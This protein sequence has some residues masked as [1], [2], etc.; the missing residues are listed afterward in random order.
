[1]QTSPANPSTPDGSPSPVLR[2]FLR[3][4]ADAAEQT[5][6]RIRI[7][8]LVLVQIRLLAVALPAFLDGT[9]KHW[10][11]TAVIAGG[12]GA[13]IALVRAI[14]AAPDKDRLLVLSTVLDAVLAFLIVLPSVVWPRQGYLGVIAAPDF[15][16][17]PLVATGAGLRL[18]RRAA[19]AGSSAAIAGVLGLVLIDQLANADRIA[20]GPAEVALAAVLM[21]GATLLALGLERRIRSLVTRGAD[22]ALRAE[23]AR[24]RLGAYVSEEVAAK[25]MREPDAMFGTERLDAAVLFSDLRGFTRTGE[26]MEPDVLIAELNAY[27]DAMVPQISAHGGVVDKYM[28]DAILAVFGVPE[29][30]GDEATRAIRA[31]HG[32]EQALVA[33]NDARRAAGLV[34]LAHGIGVHFGP[35]AAGHVGT[36]ERLQYTVIGDTVNVTSRLQTATKEAGVPVLLSADVVAR[37]SAEGGGV[38]ATRAVPP[39]ELRGRSGVVEVHTFAGG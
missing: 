36:R 30:T 17:W 39:V 33:H 24:Q 21:V 14:T 4:A 8:I 16:I 12:I 22:E 2:Q 19:I 29:H 3:Q 20:Y 5:T 34:P 9:I 7:G 13:S 11:T 23:R 37:A 18:S 26:Q 38:P 28:G 1:M 27:L 10:L 32:M 35:V 25:V 6:A 15:G 31:A